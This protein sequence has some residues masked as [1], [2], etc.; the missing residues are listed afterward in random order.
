MSAPAHH[1]ITLDAQQRRRATAIKTAASPNPS[2]GE[3]ADHTTPTAAPETNLAAPLTVPIYTREA[4][5]WLIWDCGL[6]RR[7]VLSADGPAR[8]SSL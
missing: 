7:L 8:N 3:T 4:N 1:S 5:P 2:T 6:C